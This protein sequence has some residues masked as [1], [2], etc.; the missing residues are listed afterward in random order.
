MKVDSFSD[1]CERKVKGKSAFLSIIIYSSFGELL[2]TRT[3]EIRRNSG[4]KEGSNEN[5]RQ[6]S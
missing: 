4:R 1:I 2:L 5:L 3:D 6:K